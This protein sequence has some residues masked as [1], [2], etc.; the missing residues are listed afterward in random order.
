MRVVRTVLVVLAAA[1][2]I[3]ATLAIV[4]DIRP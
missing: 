2:I 3:A 4:L 1:T